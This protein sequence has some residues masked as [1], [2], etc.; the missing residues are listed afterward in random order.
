M[1]ADM[2]SLVDVDLVISSFI[3]DV[4]QLPGKLEAKSATARVTT[5]VGA[6][7]EAQALEVASTALQLLISDKNQ[8]RSNNELFWGAQKSI[9]EDNSVINIGIKSIPGCNLFHALSACV[10]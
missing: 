3:C 4:L 8:S 7:E 2:R 9:T 1:T 6:D 10:K 5:H